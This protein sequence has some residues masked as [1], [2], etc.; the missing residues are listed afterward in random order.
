MKAY[1]HLDGR[2]SDLLGLLL[3]VARI[4]QVEQQK[5]CNRREGYS[6]HNLIAP[7]LPDVER[8]KL[9]ALPRIERYL[10]ATFD[11]NEEIVTGIVGRRS[12]FR[13]S[14]TPGKSPPREMERAR[15]LSSQRLVHVLPIVWFPNHGF[16][17]GIPA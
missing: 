3:F 16:F 11:R 2:D 7:R 14:T 1:A 5:P 15:G 10:T 8:T 9:P 13:G 17:E 6:F 4:A 12:Q